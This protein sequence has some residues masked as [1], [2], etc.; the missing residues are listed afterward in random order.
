LLQDFVGCVTRLDLA[1]D[2]DVAFGD[3]APPNLMVALSG[4]LEAAAVLLEKLANLTL[5]ASH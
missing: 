4:T 5:V 1:V 3:G 2:C